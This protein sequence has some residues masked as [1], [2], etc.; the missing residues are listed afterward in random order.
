MFN[1]INKMLINF[2][3]FNIKKRRRF[4]HRDLHKSHQYSIYNIFDVHR[5]KRI[6]TNLF[7]ND[8]YFQIKLMTV[9]G[10]KKY[11]EIFYFRTNFKQSMSFFLKMHYNLDN[12]LFF[13]IIKYLKLKYN[14]LKIK[15]VFFFL[16]HR[17]DVFFKKYL[18][19]I[20][21][22]KVSILK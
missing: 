8:K 5:K 11:K 4:G 2:S 19:D 14:I 6:G 17:I 20:S 22:E 12:N 3:S 7:I 9:L 18:Y 15:D 13:K 16:E 10:K 1:K 21:L